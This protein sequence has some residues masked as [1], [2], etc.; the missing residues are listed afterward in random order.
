MCLAVCTSS[1]PILA[2]MTPDGPF[3]TL[4]NPSLLYLRQLFIFL[5]LE[6][7]SVR[8]SSW[9]E[10]R[11]LSLQQKNLWPLTA[12]NTWVLLSSVP[13]VFQPTP[14]ELGYLIML[15]TIPSNLHI[16]NTVPISNIPLAIPDTLLSPLRSRAKAN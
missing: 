1:H 9:L 5:N 16:L 13:L 14:D 2:S 3:S 11:I 15:N 7:F 4:S 8:F 12:W 6:S 10:W